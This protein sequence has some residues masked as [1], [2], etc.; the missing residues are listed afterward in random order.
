MDKKP[1]V[2][3]CE[4]GKIWNHIYE[5]FEGTVYIP[6]NDLRD[7]VLNYGFV[8]PFLI[9][10]QDEKMSE[11]EMVFFARE[12]G[13]EKL[14]KD[15]A[16]SILFV[17]PNSAKGWENAPQNILDEIISNSKIHQYYED[18]MAKALNRFTKSLE[19]YFIRGA[20][21]RICMYGFNKSADYLA[22]YGIAHFEGD[23]LWG[24]ADCAPAFI[25]LSNPT[26]VPDI[27]ANDIPIACYNATEEICSKI[28]DNAKYYLIKHDEDIY[29]DFY[30]FA[31]KFRRML[32]ELELD[33]DLEAQGMII[34]S[35]VFEVATSPDNDGDDK[36]T[37]KHEIGYFAFYNKD[38]FSEEPAPL[39]ISF[40]GGGDSAMYIAHV[41]GWAKIAHKYNF[42]L[43][44]IENHLNSTATEMKELILN[45]QQKF[46]IDSTRIYVSGFSMGGCKS[47]DMI[48]EYPNIL[49]AAAPMD[50]TFE[51]GLNVYGQPVNK[52]INRSE[53]VPIFYVGGELTPLPELPF[54]A[55]KCID[56]AGYVFEINNIPVKYDVKLE[57]VS[58]WE[59]KIWGINGHDTLTLKDPLRQGVLTLQ[60]FES[61][62][63]NCNTVL[64]SVDNQGHECREHTCEMAYRY[65][66]CFRRVDGR[67]EKR[68]IE[69]IKKIF[70]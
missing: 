50:A 8:A 21:F 26:V 36:G 57:E 44:S 27:K 61:S 34:E 15:F 6:N 63:G 16:T 3:T 39:L 35:G 68:S 46:N 32:G 38:I 20:I 52:K 28:K 12:K 70:E 65:M 59:N 19:G 13:L 4:G 22:R 41:S 42:L 18:G 9:V 37:D 48:Q 23:G 5:R 66:S 10:L 67:I 14:A 25:S 54:Q 56:R 7:D 30:S 49:A 24:R 51:V 40:H 55:Q 31:R 17:Y 33:P 29:N 45:L 11:E 58:E 69:E 43:V 64:G 60:L 2:R 47:W 62:D 1:Q 53:S